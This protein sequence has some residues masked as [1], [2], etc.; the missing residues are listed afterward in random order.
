MDTCNI[1]KQPYKTRN[2][3]KKLTLHDIMANKIIVDFDQNIIFVASE[4]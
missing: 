2:K 1:S 3:Y 4:K